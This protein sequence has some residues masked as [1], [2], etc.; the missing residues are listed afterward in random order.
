MEIHSLT[1]DNYKQFKVF[2]GI[3]GERDN[4]ISKVSLKFLVGNNGS[5]KTT[6]MQAIGLIFTRAMNDESPGF[7]YEIIY[8]IVRG[9]K[10]T[11]IL[12]TND[13]SKYRF[14]GRLHIRISNDSLASVKKGRVIKERFSE[15]DDLHPRRIVSFASG[16]NN[17]LEGVL[18]DSPLNAINS[19]I[20]D[21]LH[22]K[23]VNSSN[24]NYLRQLRGKL[25]YEPSSLNFDSS[26][27]I[28][29]LVALLLSNPE[30]SHEV[31]NYISKK[32]ELL[33]MVKNI[34]PYFI[35]L[36]IDEESFRK[37]QN[38][39]EDKKRYERLFL[40]LVNHS[41][42]SSKVKIVFRKDRT[43][44]LAVRVITFSVEQLLSNNP[45]EF[46]TMLM[47]AWREDYLYTTNIFLKH[48]DTDNLL[49][50]TSLSDGEYLW[51]CRMALIILSQQEHDENTL[52][53]FDEPDVFLNENWTMQFISK[54]HEFIKS[55]KKNEKKERYNRQEYW[56]A[57]H[58]T[59]ILTDA[60]PD[61]TY[62]IESFMESDDFS[63]GAFEALPLSTST[64]AADRSEVSMQ[65]FM[66]QRIGEYSMQYINNK[67]D[68]DQTISVEALEKIVDKIGPGYQRY[69]MLEYL[70]QFRNPSRGSSNRME[71]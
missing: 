69:R 12:L 67:L 45:T 56:I 35:S 50:H 8:S 33:L 63:K 51:L 61:Q 21:E 36:E 4:D 60:F 43:A 2:N 31:E 64:F 47:F 26:N 52:F 3:F 41:E 70:H 6:V 32:N 37:L 57:T 24:L 18:V 54:L 65:L 40:E 22:K 9:A 53:L 23:E 13:S 1:L 25:L 66:D 58:S 29:I 14:K 28:L 20:Y 19:D 16:P 34:T 5:G 68:R 48:N 46:L 11:Y 10:T 38:S 15:R 44:P 59:L 27:A 30:N 42:G 62:M 71:N 55:T 39:N 17:S 7:R 49:D